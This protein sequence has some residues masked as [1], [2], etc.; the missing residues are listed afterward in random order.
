MSAITTVLAFDFGASTGRAIR[1]VYDGKRLDCTEIHRFDNVPVVKDRHLRWNMEA[2]LREVSIAIEKAG[3]IDSL[4]FDTWGV[5]FGLLDAEGRLLEDPVHYRDER[6]AGWSRRLA[7]RI[8]PEELYAHTGNQILEINTLFQLCALQAEQPEVYKRAKHLLFLPD[9]LAAQL[10]A[11]LTW[12]KSIASTSQMWNPRTG[13]WD[14]ELLAKLGLDGQLLGKTTDSATITGT[15][16]NGTKI[17]AVAGHDTQCAVAAMPT[18]EGECAAFLSCGTWSLIGCELEEPILTPE[19]CNSGLSNEYGANGRINYLKNI[20]GLWLIQESRREYARQGEDYSFP[21]L[22]RLAG[23]A[24]PLACFIDPD[25]PEFVAPG[26]IPE[27]I[28]NF[29]RRTG[30]S[31]PETVGEIARCIYESL[32]LKYRYALEQLETMTGRSFTVLH[33]LGGGA[34]AEILCQM[35][36]DSCQLTVQAGPVEAT[37]L[38]NI[39]L[40]LQA[41][42]AIRDIDEGRRLIARTEKIIK[43]QPQDTEHNRS[44]W[45]DAY[46]RFKTILQMEKE[47]KL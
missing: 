13:D 19:S 45:D 1:A 2:L 41:L 46:E 7:E 44:V 34:N 30:Q 42:S 47:R 12:E 25:A 3:R 24:K 21:E 35:T 43:Y 32:A 39:I 33:I 4:A 38:G 17:I 31:V 5:D 23:E 14:A 9:L 15:L 6:T 26:N 11:K 8:A 29:C 28:R 16:K 22:A 27:R 20:I 37:A 10:G 36:A 18:K 40:Q